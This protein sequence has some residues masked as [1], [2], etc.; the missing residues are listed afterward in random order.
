MFR[1]WFTDLPVRR[2]I[3]LVICL[4]SMALLITLGISVR[5]VWAARN[6]AQAMYQEDLQSTGA[7]SIYRTGALTSMY[8]TY[9]YFQ[10]TSPKEMEDIEALIQKTDGMADEA[11]ARYEKGMLTAAQREAAPK[12]RSV[13]LEQRRIRN[14]VIF[15]LLRKRQFELANK[16]LHEQ[17]AGVDSILPPLGAQLVKEGSNHAA[18]ALKAGETSAQRG[19]TLAAIVAVI[20]VLLGAFCG[21]ALVRGVDVPLKTFGRVLGRLAEGDLTVKADMDD[22]KDEFGS[23]CQ[24][25]NLTIERLRT[26]L[27]EVSHGVEGMTS[28]STQLSASADEMASTSV[29]IARVAEDMRSGGE[30][31]AAAVTELSAS[32]EEV[33]QGTQASLSRLDEAVKATVRGEGAGTTTQTAMGEIAGTA[34]RISAAVGVIRE[35]ANQTNLLSLNAAIEAAKAGEHGKGFSVVAEEVRKL[36]ERSGSS[37]K[38]IDSLLTAAR[39]AVGRGETTVA[40]TVDILKTIRF[41]LDEFASQVRAMAVAA[42]EQSNVGAEVARQVETSAQG[43]ATVASAISEMSASTTEVAR[44]AAHLH[45]LSEGLQSQVRHFRL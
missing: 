10:A 32:I 8:M 41:G 31:M 25:L 4:F 27:Q 29:E 39:E 12:Y 5:E 1:S 26:L 23:L 15:P 21:W 34:G 19:M 37:A 30:R 35:I 38:E 36:A 40:T 17:L 33:N 9:K 13:S 16:L 45:Q 6:R 2:K 28:G 18:E 20:G 43:S 24:A 42:G 14:E 22:R 7:F 44:T 3:S 11:W